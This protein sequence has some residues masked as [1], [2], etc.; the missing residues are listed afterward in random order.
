M[1]K[2]AIYL[3]TS[4]FL[5]QDF[6]TLGNVM[7]ELISLLKNN[8]NIVLLSNSIVALEIKKNIDRFAQITPQ[9]KYY[10]TH[11]EIT[12]LT[13]SL[14]KNKQEFNR[15]IKD[16]FL[17]S[18]EFP[19]NI[20]SKEIIEGCN[21]S[22]DKEG[23][24]IKKK[25]DEWKD[26]FVQQSLINIRENYKKLI[27]SSRDEGFLYMETYGIDV[28]KTPLK[29][30]LDHLKLYLEEERIIK[31]KEGFENYLINKIYTDL[32]DTIMYEIEGEITKNTGVDGFDVRIEDIKIIDVGNHKNIICE[33]VASV[34]DEDVSNATWDSEEKRYFNPLEFNLDVKYEISISF[35]GKYEETQ[36]F[37]DKMSG[38]EDDNIISFNNIIR[39]ISEPIP[40]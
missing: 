27:I 2:T 33:V 8:E 29:N 24:W 11:S 26:F 9:L 13:T 3:D 10:L 5:N 20:S 30:F 15:I 34:F 32:E 40:F 6:L 36:L 12:C 4:V 28:Q 38:I 35:E 25:P 16:L 19:I 31:D 37:K 22:Y 18:I 21:R 7:K 14:K 17:L 23:P 1:K 39:E